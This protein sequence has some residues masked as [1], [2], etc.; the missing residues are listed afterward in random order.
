MQGGE[1][2]TLR[3]LWKCTTKKRNNGFRRRKQAG[4]DENKKERVKLT[5]YEERGEG[6]ERN[7]RLVEVIKNNS[8]RKREDDGIRGGRGQ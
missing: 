4:S 5:N 7:G 3:K 2:E 1:K 6:N 8:E